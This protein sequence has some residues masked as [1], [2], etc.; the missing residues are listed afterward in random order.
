MKHFVVPSLPAPG[1]A[2]S[3]RAADVRYLTRVR[4]H[5]HGD[6]IRATDGA[7]NVADL[8]LTHDSKGWVL[9]AP[10]SGASPAASVAIP[11]PAASAVQRVPAPLVVVLALLKGRK[12][13]GVIRAAVQLG[14]TRFV[15]V[16]TA[17]SISRLS[18][19]VSRRDRFDA[20]I[21][22]ATQQSGRAWTPAVT[23]AST[24]EEALTVR[25]LDD[26]AT[27]EQ[28]DVRDVPDEPSGDDS[29]AVR[30]FLDER[31]TAP[32]ATGLVAHAPIVYLCVGP[33]GGFTDDERRRFEQAGWQG[34]TVSSAVLRSETA[35]IAA[36]AIVQHAREMER[37]VD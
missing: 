26:G 11:A 18:R 1:D 35:A 28:G 9:R 27:A 33:E 14:A 10:A 19:E 22:E 24:F 31:A 36:V 3:L 2:V 15:L 8:V 34:V 7:G 5:G 13:D 32:L 37:M 25:H 30:L 16:E 12:L 20:I 29:A 21:R 6:T 4:R 23:T 17:N